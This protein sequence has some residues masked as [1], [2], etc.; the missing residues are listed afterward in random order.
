[1]AMVTATLL[2]MVAA[3]NGTG[4][5]I[6]NATASARPGLYLRSAP[7]TATHVTFCLG[8]RHRHALWYDRLC[9]PDLPDGPR[10]LKRVA[11]V[12]GDLVMVEGDGQRA[13]DSR[14]LGPIRLNEIRGWWVPIIQTGGRQ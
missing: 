9:S 4:W 11:S 14:F 10:V 7:D 2:G 8:E 13:L 6:G 1:M 12:H 5:I 3:A